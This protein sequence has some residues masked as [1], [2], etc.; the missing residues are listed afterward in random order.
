M[1]H[2]VTFQSDLE[3]NVLQRIVGDL[4]AA[5]PFAEPTVS[6]SGANRWAALIEPRNP[7][8]CVGFASVAEFLL[9]LS[10]SAEIVSVE[11]V[12]ADARSGDF[13]FAS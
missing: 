1:R 3:G 7:G 6:A 13:A 9:R 2:T 11:R 4:A 8:M 12:D 5:G 10:R